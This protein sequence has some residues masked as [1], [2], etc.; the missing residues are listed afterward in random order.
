MLF[1]GILLGAC[2]GPE[3]LPGKKDL[4]ISPLGSQIYPYKDG[5]KL[6]LRGELLAVEEQFI[7]I[8]LEETNRNVAIDK[9]MFNC[10]ELQIAQFDNMSFDIIMVIASVGN[11][12][13]G[14][15]TLPLNLVTAIGMRSA[16]KNEVLFD[17]F[18]ITQEELYQFARYPAGLPKGIEIA[19]IY[20]AK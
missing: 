4:A 8:R 6:L 17:C 13:L 12:F 3:Y 19:Q 18:Q 15:L 16:S 9:E 2:K 20:E 11:G 14:M 10:Y 7:Y 1:A 5:A